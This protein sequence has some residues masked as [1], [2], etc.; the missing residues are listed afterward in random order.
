MGEFLL[1]LSCN[2]LYHYNHVDNQITERFLVMGDGGAYPDE[3]FQTNDTVNPP[4]P[5]VVS[6][7][8]VGIL[9]EQEIPSDTELDMDWIIPFHTVY[10]TGCPQPH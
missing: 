3:M 5:C 10:D 9:D 8:S 2:Q 1:W 6:V 4:M 7:G